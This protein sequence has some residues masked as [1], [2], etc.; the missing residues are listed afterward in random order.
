M[1]MSDR[2]TRRHLLRTGTA[3]LGLAT[4]GTFL[5]TTEALAQT[6]NRN[7]RIRRSVTDSAGSP[8]LASYGRAVAEMKRRSEVNANDPLGWTAQANIHRDHCPHGNW[9][10]LPCGQRREW[11][12]ACADQPVG[13][14]GSATERR[15]ISVTASR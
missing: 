9:F 3:A 14:L 8:A 1:T 2:V 10:F 12:S 5:P 15:F 4:T 6:P 11:M 13:S 7:L